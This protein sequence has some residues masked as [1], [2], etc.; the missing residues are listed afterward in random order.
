MAGKGGGSAIPSI[1]T[2][3]SLAS[4][5]APQRA[6]NSKGLLLM[7]LGMFLFSAVDTL[8]KYLTE[9]MHP[10]QIVWTRQLG[11]LV[12][13]IILLFLHGPKLLQTTQPVLQCLRGICAALSATIFI[14]AVTYVPLA[15]AVAISFVAPFI[16]TVLAALLLREPVGVRRWLAVCIGFVGALIVIRPG[17]GLVHP[18][19]GLVV[20][21]AGL[22][23]LRQILSR[24]LSGS[25][26]TVT[27]IAYTAITSFILLSIPLYFVWEWPETRQVIA[28]CI[29]MA[30][31]AAFAEICVIK[32]L[33][34]T[35]AVVVAPVHYSLIIWATFYGFVVF[36]DFPDAWTW[37]GTS[38]IM[39]TGIYTLY[40][41]HLATQRRKSLAAQPLNTD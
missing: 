32:S 9:S 37:L 24:Y 1:I 19:A 20:L 40:R 7:A 8:A 5:Q 2:P 36:G 33:E 21:A 13:A 39:A 6:D 15:D 22:F 3:S 4:A 27:T 34:M 18:A 28:L 41:E 25:D 26:R 11:L 30:V 29:G 17:M 23:A 16:V 14:F 31:L 10:I 35:M 12:G 38:I